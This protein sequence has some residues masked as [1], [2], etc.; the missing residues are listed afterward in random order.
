[1]NQPTVIV[2]G[3]GVAGLACARELSRRGVPVRVLERARGVGGRCATRRVAGDQPVDHGVPF[4]HAASGE[5]RQ[6]FDELD[7]AGKIPGWPRRVRQPKLAC[8]PGAFNP[9]RRR[10][11][12]REGLSAFPKHLARGL[13]VELN[14]TVRALRDGEGEVAVEFESGEHLA[15]RFVV[16]ACAV[17]QSLALAAPCVADWSG[18]R[19]ALEAMRAIRPIRT[20]TVI[21]GYGLDVPEPPFDIWYPIETT[22]LH[23]ISH[24]SAKRTAPSS[25]V[26]VL[27]A[28]PRYS[29]EYLERPAEE[30]RDELVWEAGELLGAWAARPAWTQTHRWRSARVRPAELLGESPVF[31]S[32]RGGRVVVIGDAFARDPGLEG[33]YMSGISVGEQV[34]TLP[35]VRESRA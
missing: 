3:A 21:A 15:A 22:M 28:R 33:A 7:P 14:R 4:L 32:P 1:M 26:L 11:A 20:L 18:A 25:R 16:L 12:R 8:Q 6:A 29:E 5:F 30:W 27:Q 9:G 23:T 10:Q 31:E 2:V 35:S 17:D 24:D 34:A 19:G 13:E